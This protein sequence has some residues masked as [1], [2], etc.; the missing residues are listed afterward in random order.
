MST[1]VIFCGVVRILKNKTPIN[2]AKRGDKALTMP[3]NELLI[4][5]SAMQ[6]KK[7]GMKLPIAAEDT[8]YLVFP[9]GICRN[10]RKPIGNKTTPEL[11]IRKAAT[12]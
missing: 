12:W 3:A 2:I 5:S 11:K 9:F 8:I 1:E 7:A 4:C 6:N 10:W